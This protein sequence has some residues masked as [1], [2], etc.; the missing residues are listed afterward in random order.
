MIER[1]PVVSGNIVSAGYD[2][3]VNQMEVEFRNSGVYTFLEVP[4]EVYAAFETAESKGKYFVASIRGRYG[5]TK[6]VASAQTPAKGTLKVASPLYLALV[7]TQRLIEDEEGTPFPYCLWVACGKE[8]TS[9]KDS[10]YKQ[11]LQ[12]VAAASPD[13]KTLGKEYVAGAIALARERK[14]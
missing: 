12:L 14:I 9:K 11:C 1:K 8:P 3:K 6:S 5:F 10:R 2:E 7:K 4:P 13:G